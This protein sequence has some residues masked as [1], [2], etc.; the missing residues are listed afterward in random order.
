[1]FDFFVD[2]Y[3]RKLSKLERKLDLALELLTTIHHHQE[4][5][6]SELGTKL[7]DAVTVL[8]QSIDEAQARVITRLEQEDAAEAA[9]LADNVA[10]QAEMDRLA[11]IIAVL[12]A[13]PSAAEVQALID[14]LAAAQAD[15]ASTLPPV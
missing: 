7:A 9:L 1:M 8:Q 10:K 12:E 15:I 11:A 4:L 3:R 13:N 14:Q 2:T 6:M 5:N